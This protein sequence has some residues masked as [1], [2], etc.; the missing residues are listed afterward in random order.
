MEREICF[1]TETTGL[2]PNEGHRLIEIGC[3]EVIDGKRTDNCYHV[4]INPERDVPEEA[5][6]VHHI[7]T[8]MLADKPKFSAIIEDFLNFIQD[9]TLVAH[10]AGFDIKFIN[11][12]LSLIGRENLKNKVVDSLALAKTI[13]PTQRNNLDALCKRYN[14]NNT[15]REEEGHG[16]LLDAE[17]LADVYIKM[18]N[19]LKEKLIQDVKNEKT[20]NNIDINQLMNLIDKN[21]I[22]ESRNFSIDENE[23]QKHNEFINKHIKNSLWNCE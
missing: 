7:T 22:I 10:N 15:K 8:E 9:S 19:S 11:H 14:V 4:L 17:L 6:R 3:V 1:D 13:F 5:V 2:N 23:L 21:E 18:T 16:A 20:E 12:E